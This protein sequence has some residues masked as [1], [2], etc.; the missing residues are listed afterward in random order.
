MNHLIE[1]SDK[2]IKLLF[3]VEDRIPS[4]NSIYEFNRKN[5]A[6]H[7]STAANKIY[8]V[9][10]SQISLSGVLDLIPAFVHGEPYFKTSYQF[11]IRYGL[12]SRDLSNM[13]KLV[14]DA[15][16]RKLGIDDFRVIELN[17]F[18][19]FIGDSQYEFII[20]EISKTDF[21]THYFNKST[22]DK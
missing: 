20:F 21:D 2:S 10:Q 22:N 19:S 12:R 11:V 8:S 6:I 3:R 9:I 13:L 15:I 1:H 7:K 18:K 16:H 4:V 14:E 5:G 17:A